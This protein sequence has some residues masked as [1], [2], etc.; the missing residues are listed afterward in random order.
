MSQICIGRTINQ[1]TDGNEDLI[2]HLPSKFSLAE[3]KYAGNDK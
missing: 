2:D 3:Q 1:E